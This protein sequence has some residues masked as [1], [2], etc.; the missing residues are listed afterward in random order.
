MSNKLGI[1][2]KI[3]VTK[4]EKDR[5]FNG[6]KGKWLTITAFVDPDNEGQYGDHGMVTHEK[7]KGEQQA[8]ILGNAKVFWRDESAESHLQRAPQQQ[9]STQPVPMPEGLPAP[10]PMDN[11]DDD[12]PF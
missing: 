2:F 4:I 7:R 8:P 5:I 6:K 1:S 11:F 3:D 12:L 9:L 10:A